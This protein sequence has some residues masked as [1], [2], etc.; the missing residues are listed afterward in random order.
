M[1]KHQQPKVWGVRAY[2][3]YSDVDQLDALLPICITLTNGVC[4]VV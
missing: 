3:Q 1:I 2:F 4:K